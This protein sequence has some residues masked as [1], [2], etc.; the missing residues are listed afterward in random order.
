MEV[1]GKPE[2]RDISA[3]HVWE[4]NP[5]GIMEKGF[6]RLKKQ[7]RKLGQ[8]KPLLVIPD[9]TVLGGNMRLR[10]MQE[11]GVKRV[12]VNVV[13]PKSE[14]EKMEYALSDN[15]R[16]GYYE[17]EKLVELLAEMEGEIDQELYRVD[18]G[19]SVSIKRLLE[20]L[21]PS[22]VEVEEDIDSTAE[23]LDRYQHGT[24]RQIVLYFTIKKYEEV[25]ARLKTITEE[26]G[27]GNNTEVFLKLLENYE[28]TKSEADKGREE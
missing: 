13:E 21:G 15:D 28:N 20:T 19:S 27:A 7:I 10:A 17:D 9:G 18:F 6:A 25:V 23:K 5:R 3:L 16:V 22:E 12:W 11:L 4:K 26:L 8:Y 24:I 14:A 2:I 1:K